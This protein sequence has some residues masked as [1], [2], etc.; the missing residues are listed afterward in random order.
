MYCALT[1]DGDLHYIPAET[2]P[3]GGRLEAPCVFEHN[4]QRWWQDVK[5]NDWIERLSASEY[6]RR[7]REA[8]SD[9]TSDQKDGNPLATVS[10]KAS[11]ARAELEGMADDLRESLPGDRPDTDTEPLTRI[12]YEILQDDDYNARRKVLADVSEH[13][14]TGGSDTIERRLYAELYDRQM[15]EG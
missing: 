5:H 14:A 13:P 12:L 6:E 9:D 11:A 8:P 2:S 7:R 3:T 4:D 15:A 1:G 10:A